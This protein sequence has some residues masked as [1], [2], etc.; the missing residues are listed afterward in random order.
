[1]NKVVN[2]GNIKIS[3]NLP[4]VLIAGPC[5]LENSEHA[6][7]MAENLVNI[8]S[9]LGIK[10][11]YKS[12]FDK[13]NRSNINAKRGLGLDKSLRIFED[14]KKE[15]GFPIITDVHDESQCSEVASVVDVLQIPAFLC[16]QTDL[17]ISAGKTGKAINIKKGQFLG[18][19]NMSEIA[20]KI[21]STGN[22]NI[23]LCERGV[24]FGYNHLV[25]DMTSLPIMAQTGYPVIL[26]ATHSVQ[27]I[28]LTSQSNR[29]MVPYIAKAGVATGVAGLFM[30]VH[31]DPQNAPSDSSNMLKLF[32]LE[33]LLYTLINIDVIIKK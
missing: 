29:D 14:L 31:Q 33:N 19:W 13:A 25:V 21:S 11:I 28:G 4:F 10:L 15:F 7:F 24:C 26:D 18:P 32:D 3:N 16:R 2:I 1:M 9:K 27:K 17:L 20:E 30:E 12:S 22:E 8:T 23:L 5:V 6:F